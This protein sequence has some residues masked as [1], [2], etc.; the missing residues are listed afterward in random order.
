MKF[1]ECQ[2][3]LFFLIIHYYED[4]IFPQTIRESTFSHRRNS[5]QL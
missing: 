5:P 2:R 3:N 1:L 4:F